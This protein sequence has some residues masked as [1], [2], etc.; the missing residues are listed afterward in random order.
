MKKEVKK[1]ISFFE[2]LINHSQKKYEPSTHH[3]LK[4]MIIPL[5]KQFSII[6]NEG[7]KNDAWEVISGF[8][9]GCKRI[10]EE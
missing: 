5:C 8:A 10:R 2:V 7:T 3:I 9:Q 6:I 1:T 4:R